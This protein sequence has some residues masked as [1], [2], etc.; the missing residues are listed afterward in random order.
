MENSWFSGSSELT[1]Y[2]L[3]ELLGT[4]LLALYQRKKGRDIFDLY[5]ALSITEVN[6]EVLIRCYKRYMD[7]S[8][9]KPPTYRQFIQNMESKMVDPDFMGDMDNLLHS[10]E[11]YDMQEAYEIVKEKIIDRLH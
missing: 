9:S 5:K 2:V 11:T 1:I 3:E 8:V 4:K 10:D 6:P 7:F